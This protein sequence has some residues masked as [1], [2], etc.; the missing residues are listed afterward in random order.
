M[1]FPGHEPEGP[2]WVSGGL[3]Q[4]SLLSAI[5]FHFSLSPLVDQLFQEDD[6]P[7]KAQFIAYVDDLYLVVTSRTYEQNNKRL[8]E[9]HDKVME[10][11][12]M[13]DMAFD[14]YN[15]VHFRGTFKRSPHC[16][17]LP[18]IEELRLELEARTAQEPQEPN[19]EDE[20]SW[21]MTA[22]VWMARTTRTTGAARI[23]R[24]VRAS[25]MLLRKRRKGNTRQ[26]RRGRKKERKKAADERILK[27]PRSLSRSNAQV[28]SPCRQGQDEGAYKDSWS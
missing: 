16:D 21:T 7:L 15:L 24:M 19:E 25:Q 6:F 13:N 20:E 17:T 12:K 2:F 4:S 22:T 18:D 10:W 14:K 26:R 11:A 27:D 8:K 28:G 5:L 9:L 3:P 1:S 23:T